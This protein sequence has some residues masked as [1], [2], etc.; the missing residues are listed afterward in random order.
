[1][2]IK[3]LYLILALGSMLLCITVYHVVNVYG[4]LSVPILTNSR[5]TLVVPSVMSMLP[6]YWN[7]TNGELGSMKVTDAS[8]TLLTPISNLTV[9]HYGDVIKLRLDAKDVNGRQRVHGGDFWKA[10]LT[11]KN[12][13]KCSV[14]GHVEDL[15]NGTYFVTFV[16]KCVGQATI[17]ISLT[18]T[19]EAV[20]CLEREFIPL[21]DKTAWQGY[22]GTGAKSSHTM[23]WLH[24][25]GTWENKC[26]YRSK[27]GLGR[28]LL[29]CDKP[30]NQSC[31]SLHHLVAV[32]PSKTAVDV[33]SKHKHLFEKESK[34]VAETPKKI[35]IFENDRNR[36]TEQ[37]PHCSSET[38]D[39]TF[40]GHWFNG[41][42][43]PA[44]CR[45]QKIDVTKVKSCL[46]NK[47]I[48][49]FGDS[50]LRQWFEEIC[51]LLQINATKTM[52][53]TQYRN[54]NQ[55]SQNTLATFVD[56]ENRIQT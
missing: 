53:D 37:L 30:P 39:K 40:Q 35:I 18:H 26:E 54:V 38:V 50:T 55:R 11:N 56:T 24:R 47:N 7:S 46:A 15:G 22:F 8:R 10:L 4:K 21:E 41:T 48:L 42:W 6:P 13:G 3:R 12:Y 34:A 44:H 31:S 29:L 2:N 36:V 43:H 1:M 32:F 23:C 17:V 49:L 45:T 52:W 19:R 25:E 51:Q 27:T 20:R 28:S 33:A 14:P 9:I 16:A 5:K